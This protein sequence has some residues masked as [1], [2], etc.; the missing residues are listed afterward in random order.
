MSSG[1]ITPEDFLTPPESP[2]P[3]PS[4][5]VYS[6]GAISPLGAPWLDFSHQQLFNKHEAFRNRSLSMEDKISCNSCASMCVTSFS[7]VPVSINAIPTSPHH[8]YRIPRCRS[9]PSFYDRK[10]GRRR[11]RDS[12]PT[13]NFHKMTE[14]GIKYHMGLDMRKNYFVECKQQRLNP[15]GAFT[16]PDH[17]YLESLVAKLATHK[18]SI[19]R[20]SYMCA[21]VLLNL[22]NEF[23]KRNKML[24]KPGIL[25]LFSN[26]F[27]K[28][29]IT[30][31]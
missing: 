31:A 25:S 10:S 15:A 5:A 21:Y 3:R 26:K 18:M 13:L 30:S 4:S 8:R 20:G 14:V 9:Q 7:S 29:N 23:G 27:N 24:V 22:L 1:H 19:N 16:Q 2:I 11:R 28:F 12:R 6:D 17:C